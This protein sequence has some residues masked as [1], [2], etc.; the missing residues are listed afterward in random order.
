MIV[1]K[2]VKFDTNEMITLCSINQIPKVAD[3]ERFKTYYCAIT[4]LVVE[5]TAMPPISVAPTGP[6]K[7]V[8]L[9]HALMVEYGL[10]VV[11]AE[12]SS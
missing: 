12:V 8:A 2:N 7:M 6:K 4:D 3:E 10:M 1:D 5:T 9:L 11:Y